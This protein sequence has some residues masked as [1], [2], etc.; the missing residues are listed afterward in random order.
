[1]EHE[2]KKKEKKVKMNKYPEIL[3]PAGSLASLKA[4]VRAGA[5]AVYIGAKQFNARQRSD[6]FTREE[7]LESVLLCHLH[8]VKLYAT[9]NI[10]IK[11]GEMAEAMALVGDLYDMGLDGLIVQDLGFA[12]LIR[13]RYPDFPLHSSTQMF[14]HGSLGVALLEELGFERVVLA[15]ELTLEEI[16]AIKAAAKAEIKIFCHGALCI[17]YS[18]QCYMSS[19]IGGRSGNRGRCAQPCRKSYSLTD[20][21]GRLVKKG[22]LISPKDLNTLE[23]LPEIIETGVDSLKIEGRLKNPEY[24]HTAVRAYREGVDQWAQNQQGIGNNAIHEVF[25]R[26]Y[27]SGYLQQAHPSGQDLMVNPNPSTEKIL[28]GTIDKAENYKYRFT[29]QAELFLGDGLLIATDKGGFGETLT[30]LFDVKGNP[31]DYLPVG[32]V[33]YVSLYKAAS[34][35]MIIYK[36]SDAKQ[37]QDIQQSMEEDHAKRRSFQWDVT[38]TPGEKPVLVVTMEDSSFVLEGETLVE[39]AK[40]APLSEERILEQLNKLTDTPFQ[41]E[42]IRITLNGPVFLPVSAINQLRRQTVEALQVRVLD[43]YRRPEVITKPWVPEEPTRP[44]ASRTHGVALRIKDPDR[45]ADALSSD[46]DE[47]VFGWDDPWDLKILDRVCK[48]AQDEGKP[49]RLALPRILREEEGR[50]M[51]HLMD[52]VLALPFQGFLVGSYEGLH[53]VRS[54]GKSVETDDTFNVFNRQTL[55]VLSSLGVE[56][57]YLSSELNQEELAALISPG[58]MGTGLVVHGR[59]ELMI[60]QYGLHDHPTFEGWTLTDEK[61]YGFPLAKDGFGRTHV[62]NAKVL[63]LLD[64]GPT[65]QKVDKIRIDLLQGEKN[66]KDVVGAY[67]AAVQGRLERNPAWFDEQRSLWTKGH[68]NRGVL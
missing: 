2:K 28:V 12:A 38:F 63:S 6:N 64:E 20:A 52:D 4:A 33:G 14:V 35:G 10:L 17:S 22:P 55:D 49:L 21:E 15:R 43:Q 25:N 47:I 8:G 56:L 50:R 60:L 39:E 58:G 54:L 48:Q 65:L 46:V 23:L 9:V 32:S 18:G 53:L 16:R 44:M 42:T 41:A 1:V 34:V 61:G 31:T 59:K 19:L 27:T 11:D 3:A 36:T 24:V 29:A 57:S 66:I 5:D 13:Q 40:K 45:M 26:K 7:I 67:Q 37:R 68:F 51:K 62:L 30:T